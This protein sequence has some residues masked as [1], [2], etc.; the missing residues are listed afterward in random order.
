MLSF[1]IVIN[2]YKEKRGILISQA[3][4]CKKKRGTQDLIYVALINF[5]LSCFML[6]ARALRLSKVV[7]FIIIDAVEVK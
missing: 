1:P 2:I 4:A 6:R 3:L 5:S 7:G